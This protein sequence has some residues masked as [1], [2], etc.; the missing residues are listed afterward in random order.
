MDVI[1]SSSK[2]ISKDPEHHTLTV[3]GFDIE[4]HTMKRHICEDTSRIQID[5]YDA[6]TNI[7]SDSW[8]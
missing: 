7:I 5:I 6:D 4:I 2:Y 3:R 1:I 8:T